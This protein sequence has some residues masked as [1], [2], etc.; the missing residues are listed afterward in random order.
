MRK[1]F[2]DTA[3]PR[4]LH[5]VTVASTGDKKGR[6]LDVLG[7]EGLISK[8]TFGWTGETQEADRIAMQVELS[9]TDFSA[10]CSDNLSLACI[11]KAL[12]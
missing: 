4:D 9:H 6:G 12:Q 5:L 10:A 2:D 3:E 11:S 1:R 8:Y 7:V